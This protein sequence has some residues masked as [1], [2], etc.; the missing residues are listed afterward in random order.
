MASEQTQIPVTE[1]LRERLRFVK[2]LTGSTSY[3]STI[4]MVL[5]DSDFDPP[6][7]GFDTENAKALMR[8]MDDG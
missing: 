2:V 5:E 7:G 6:E 4:D 3:T 8:E 1:E